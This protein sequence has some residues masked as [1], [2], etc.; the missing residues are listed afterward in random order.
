MGLEKML[1]IYFLQQWFDF[2]VPQAKTS[3]TTV[4]EAAL[5]VGLT[6]GRGQG[7]V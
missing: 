3:S 5:F 6:L 4:V 1:R 2:F 7:S